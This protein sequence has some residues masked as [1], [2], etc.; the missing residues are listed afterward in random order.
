MS[1]LAVLDAGGEHALV[2]PCRDLADNGDIADALTLPW[3]SR[4]TTMVAILHRARSRHLF[5]CDL[6]TACGVAHRLRGRATV[7]AQKPLYHCI[8][9]V[10]ASPV[11]LVE[12][13]EDELLARPRPY[14]A[15]V[16]LH[17]YFRVNGAVLTRG[18]VQPDSAVQCTDRL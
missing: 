13:I 7:K 6:R 11:I 10:C 15:S 17:G 4:D 2:L 5:L 12:I 16:E 8:R 18:L 9:N 3:R 1:A 14:R